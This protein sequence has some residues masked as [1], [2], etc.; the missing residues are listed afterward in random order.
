MSDDERAS[1]DF[2]AAKEDLARLATRLAFGPSTASLVKAAEE[3]GI[4]WLRL[5]EHSLVQFGH[6]KYQQRIQATI[7]SRT[8]HIAV[9]I[10]QDKQITNQLL[11]RAGLPVPRQ[12]VVRTLDG[13]LEA[14]RKLRYPLV[15]KPLDASHGRGITIGVTDEEQVRVAFANAQEHRSYVILEEYIQG[16]DHRVLVINGEVVAVSERVPG[17][18][19]G[20]GVHTLAELIEIVNSDPRR[21]VGHENVLTRLEIDHQAQRLMDQ[22]GVTA[23]TVL[24]DGRIFYL[25]STGNLS[26]GGTAIDRTDDIHYENVQIACRAAQVVGLDVAGIDF[27]TPDI[28]R[29]VSEVGGGIVEVN[30]AP[31]FRMHVAPSEGQPRDA[32][33]P[34]LDMLFPPGTPTRI[35]IAAI[36]GTNGKTTTARMTAHILKMSGYHVG[37][38]TTDGIYVDGE[39]IAR[40][41][42]TGPTSARIVLRDPTVD[43]AVLETARGGILREG[44]GFERADV[45]AVLNISADHLGLRGIDTLDD[46]ARVKSLVV[47]IV[48]RDG[49]AVLNADDERVAKLADRIKA[50]PFFFSFDPT[51]RLVSEQVRQG[52]RA[53][54]IE[55]GVNGDMITLYDRGRHIPLLWTHL[56]PAT[57]EGR[58]KFNVANAM[59]AA[60]MAYALGIS[61]ENIR[62]GLRTFS[63]SFYQTPGRLNIFDEHP[64]RVIVDYGHNAAAISG[65]VDLVGQLPHDGRTICVV[66]VPGD[67]RDDDAREIGRIIGGGGFD[68]IIIKE[69]YRLRGRSEGEMPGFIREGLEQAGVASAVV[70]YIR[71]EHDAVTK[72]LSMAERGDLVLLFADEPTDVW[73]QVIYWGKERTSDNAAIGSV[74]QAEPAAPP[75]AVPETPI[76]NAQPVSMQPSPAEH[77]IFPGEGED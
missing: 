4:P 64:F 74:A 29:P 20:D 11:E 35:P 24:E 19:V 68:Q 8:S 55:Q 37:L 65:L 66:S 58:A 38:T 39:R 23:A 69:D 17:H 25:R 62:Q 61:I 9:E 33:G 46:M 43:A 77:P 27:I 50:Q 67:R 31:G 22:A 57:L 28:S 53:I 3:R 21:G 47:E 12:R 49:W 60:A 1:F 71:Y 30:A 59:A 16:S 13:A 5:N 54:V 51:N 14:A 72:A 56:I 48:P 6:G 45:G 52:G 7:T 76:V 44:L 41:D 70:S 10:A 42:M 15:V 75:A 2:V 36:T 26:T 63:T 32:A 34:V 40:G 18:V 73:K